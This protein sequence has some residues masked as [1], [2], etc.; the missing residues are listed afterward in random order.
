MLALKPYVPTLF[1]ALS[2]VGTETVIKLVPLFMGM[3]GGK[4]TYVPALGAKLG[5]VV[6]ALNELAPVMVS[7]TVTLV[8]VFT[9]GLIMYARMES[10]ND[11]LVINFPTAYTFETAKSFN[12]TGVNR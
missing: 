11:E 12:T 1:D 7:E 6:V 10:V 2:S 8:W 9:P 5:M 4:D 3:N